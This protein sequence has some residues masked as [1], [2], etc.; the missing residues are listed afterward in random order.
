MP[1]SAAGE[2][3]D[4]AMLGPRGGSLIAKAALWYQSCQ[5]P[6]AYPLPPGNGDTVRQGKGEAEPQEA[7]DKR[8]EIGRT[9]KREKGPQTSPL[10]TRCRGPW[11]RGPPGRI[12]DSVQEIPLPLMNPRVKC[13]AS[14]P[15]VLEF[16]KN[17]KKQKTPHVVQ[18]RQ[19]VQNL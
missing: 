12:L 7:R 4:V 5:E 3:Q 16:V 15:T 14:T 9:K 18:S 11:A 17:R 6:S 13:L 2:C 19:S 8:R 1:A 10:T